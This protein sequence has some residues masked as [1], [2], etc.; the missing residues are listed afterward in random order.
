MFDFQL[1]ASDKKLEDFGQI[2]REGGAVFLRG[3]LTVF[4]VLC[5][6]WLCLSIVR[7]FLYDLP[8]R[9]QE[10]EKSTPVT[11]TPAVLPSRQPAMAALDEAELIAVLAAAVAAA[12][13]ESCPG[14]FRVV[15]FHRVNK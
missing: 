12:E 3:M 14:K 8:R 6:I 13:G 1:L 11:P 9:R 5:I 7:F 4:A 15:S 10:E 2:F